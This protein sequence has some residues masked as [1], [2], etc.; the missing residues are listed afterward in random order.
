MTEIEQLAPAA[1]TPWQVVVTAKSDVFRP[2]SV[3]ELICNGA[4]PEFESEIVDGVVATPI[5]WFPN[6]MV[7]ELNA[8][9][10]TAPGAP[11]P[12]TAI[13]NVPVIPGAFVVR[14]TVPVIAPSFV[15]AKAI[16]IVHTPPAG[17]FEDSEQSEPL[18]GC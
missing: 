9:L 7:V 1:T 14:P 8:T 10:G 16:E 13:L 2:L 6:A 4:C 17:T 5:G 15:G 18:Y 11:A 12:L 3:I